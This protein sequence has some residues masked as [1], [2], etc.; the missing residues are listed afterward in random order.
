VAKTIHPGDAAP[1]A[2]DVSSERERRKLLRY[3]EGS[4]WHI[5]TFA[6]VRSYAASEGEAISTVV[7]HAAG[8]YE[9]TA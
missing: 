1:I 7:I 2:D 5:R 9:Y 8:I 6:N 3:K 4:Y